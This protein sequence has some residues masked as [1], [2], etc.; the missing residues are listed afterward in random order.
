[1]SAARRGPRPHAG[2]AGT[3]SPGS[4]GSTFGMPSPIVVSMS[5]YDS[6][7]PLITASYSL[8]GVCLPWIPIAL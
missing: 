8:S 1:M 6:S 7:I 2:S 4:T 3:G 5:L